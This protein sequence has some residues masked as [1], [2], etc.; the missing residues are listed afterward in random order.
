[1]GFFRCSILS[2]ITGVEHRSNGLCTNALCSRACA[3]ACACSHHPAPSLLPAFPLSFP[4]LLLSLFVSFTFFLLSLFSF[5][6]SFPLLLP[7]PSLPLPSLLCLSPFPF[8]LFFFFFLPLPPY[9]LS[10]IIHLT[11]TPSM[12]GA[13]WNEG[14]YSQNCS[15]GAPNLVEDTEK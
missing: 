7:L 8:P 5:I 11:T 14:E 13:V 2:V 4:W 6:S 10:Q 3:H 9:S 12:R 1:M 15:Q